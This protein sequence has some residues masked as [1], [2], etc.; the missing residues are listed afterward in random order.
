MNVPSSI[1]PM[2]S[3]DHGLFPLHYR[4]GAPAVELAGSPLLLSSGRTCMTSLAMAG[5]ESFQRN[6]AVH[7][8]SRIMAA[9]GPCVKQGD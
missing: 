7:Q 9:E 1:E 4:S 6:F 8:C 2:H 5:L 3:P